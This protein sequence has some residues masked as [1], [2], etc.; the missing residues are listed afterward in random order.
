[1]FKFNN[2]PEKKKIYCDPVYDKLIRLGFSNPII[3]LR[4]EVMILDVPQVYN[5]SGTV[6]TA[7]DTFN[8]P[9]EDVKLN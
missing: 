5:D 4:H 6:Y 7:D 9:N 1:M 8:M 3:D 2:K